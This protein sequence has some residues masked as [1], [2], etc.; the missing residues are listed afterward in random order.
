M[1]VPTTV[2]SVT[3]DELWTAATGER[4]IV[5]REEDGWVLA[6]WEGDTPAWSVWILVDEHVQRS[7]SLMR[8]PALA[9]SRPHSGSRDAALGPTAAPTVHV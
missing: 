3:M 8:H 5:V 1:V 7:Q 2:Y 6:I 9:Y 4:Y